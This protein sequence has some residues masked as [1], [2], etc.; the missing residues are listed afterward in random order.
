MRFGPLRGARSSSL[1]YCWVGRAFENFRRLSS[2]RWNVNQPCDFAITAY[3]PFVCCVVDLSVC[4]IFLDFFVIMFFRNVVGWTLIG[5]FAFHAAI[6]RIF[7]NLSRFRS[8]I[9]SAIFHLDLVLTLLLILSAHVHEP[10]GPLKPLLFFCLF[11][12]LPPLFCHQI[13][14]VCLIF[15]RDWASSIPSGFALRFANASGFGCE[16]AAR[17]SS[18]SE[19]WR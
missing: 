2:V 6:Y 15:F 16:F 19:S 4:G 1:I 5:P 8:F 12:F 9:V 7:I 10:R 11:S 14:S 18:C 17:E 3:T 13:P